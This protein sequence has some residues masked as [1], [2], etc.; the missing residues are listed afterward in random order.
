MSA[1][2]GNMKSK[3]M[4]AVTGVRV[5]SSKKSP[6]YHTLVPMTEKQLLHLYDSAVEP[7]RKA[8][9]TMELNR[10]KACTAAMVKPR[11]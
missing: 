9:I 2:K 1:A 10:R 8:Y 6:W 4:V 7:W 3:D 5:Y 11:K